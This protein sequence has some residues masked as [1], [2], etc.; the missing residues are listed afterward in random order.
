MKDHIANPNLLDSLSA[1][2]DFIN[3]EEMEIF[4]RYTKSVETDAKEVIVDVGQI[5]QALY[6]I[7]SG[8]IILAKDD[9]EKEI[10]VGRMRAGQ[11]IGEM[12]FFDQKPREVRIR[13]SKKGVHLLRLS[14]AMYDLLRRE[15]PGLA[16]SLLEFAIVSLDKLIRATSSDIST[17]TQTIRGVGYRY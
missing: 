15:H 1:S 6:I 3:R 9:G 14:H 10:E 12:S 2:F 11:L 16:V 7:L 8:E 5:G 17:L 4:L 13:A